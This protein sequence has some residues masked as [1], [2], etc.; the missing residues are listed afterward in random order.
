MDYSVYKT[1][2]FLSDSDTKLICPDCNTGH[3]IA[4]EK[5]IKKI[6]YKKYNEDVLATEDYDIDWLKYAFHG[7]LQCDN[8]RC[9]E[10]IVVSGHLRLNYGSYESPY[11]EDEYIEINE[12]IC[13]PQ[14][15]EKPPRIIEID[16]K[17]PPDIQEI[18][19][20]SFS[21][22]WIDKASCANRLRFC[23]E[24][25]LDL[26]QVPKKQKTKKG[27]MPLSLHH[28]IVRFCKGNDKYQKILTAAK[29]IGNTGSHS[30]K[31]NANNLLNGYRLINYM[32]KELYINEEKE[33]IE[34]SKKINKTKGR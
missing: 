33:I 5:N 24:K 8:K 27:L 11:V 30:D 6:E 17:Y 31:V 21:L 14:Y 4:K 25:M 3:L 34:L 26:F 9:N 16:D 23:I 18:L 32:L 19:F 2:K 1:G 28:R 10:K 7:F 22:F 20:S 13:Y 12:E 29:W 15:F